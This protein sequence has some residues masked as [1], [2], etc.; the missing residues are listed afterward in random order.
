MFDLSWMQTWSQELKLSIVSSWTAALTEIPES[1]KKSSALA[2]WVKSLYPAADLEQV[3]EAGAEVKGNQD[4]E[5]VE[6]P[7]SAI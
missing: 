3:E 4:D 5:V 2:Q 6:K 7:E 1:W